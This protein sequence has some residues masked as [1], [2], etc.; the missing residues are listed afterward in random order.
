MVRKYY[1]F[2]ILI[3]QKQEVLVMAGAKTK[4]Q[5]STF[6]ND[7]NSSCR[8]RGAGRTSKGKRK[9]FESVGDLKADLETL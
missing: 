6:E 1:L 2:E 4:E 9:N 5:S 7:P 8:S 3:A